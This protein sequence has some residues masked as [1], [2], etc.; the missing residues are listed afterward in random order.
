MS[1]RGNKVVN[2]G[3]PSDPLDAANKG[4]VDSV[5]PSGFTPGSLPIVSSSPSGR[6][7]VQ[8]DAKYM[9]GQLEIGST[10]APGAFRMNSASGGAA[11]I[12]APNTNN[13]VVFELPYNSLNNGVLQSVGGRTAWVDPATLTSGAIKADGSVPLAK[14]LSSSVDTTP[15]QPLV[16]RGTAGMYASTQNEVKVGFSAQGSR[17]LEANA[18]SGALV[19]AT[20]VL[21]APF[22]RLRNTVSSYSS[23]TAQGMPTYS[24]A[25]ETSTGIGQSKVQS[26][27]M[28]VNG[29][30]RLT[31]GSNS[32][33]AHNNQLQALADPSLDTDAATKGYVD[34]VVKARKEL[35]FRV[36]SLPVGWSGG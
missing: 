18:S 1:L 30:P 19:G 15:A 2:V 29:S 11:I 20:D 7:Y 23:A 35:S 34:R 32:I 24:F 31:A 14:G 36:T 6:K 12:K 8:S 4:Y 26:V 28:M 21:N 3:A 5:I 25:G 9:N 17:L 27:S 16:Y 13:N 10:S 33:N 22:I